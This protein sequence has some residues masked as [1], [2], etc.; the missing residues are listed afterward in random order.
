MNTIEV[1]GQRW[2]E[3]PDGLLPSVT[4]VLGHFET[5]KWQQ[6]RDFVGDKKADKMG[7]KKSGMSVAKWEKSKADEKSDKAAV[8]KINKARK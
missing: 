2:Y 1:N 8:K 6:W 7:A 5:A 3:T 4:T